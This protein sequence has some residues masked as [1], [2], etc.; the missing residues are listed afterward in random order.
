MSSK[1]EHYYTPSPQSILTVRE[2]GLKLPNGRVYRFKSPSGVFSY[3]R[4]DRASRVLINNAVLPQDGSL[5]DLG[6]GYGC[7][8]IVICKEHE[9]LSLHMSDINER[10]VRFSA[11]NARD[12]N[13]EAD[14]R[15]GNLFEPWT[16]MS[17]DVIVSNPPIAAGRAVLTELVNRAFTSLN[18]GGY[19]ELVAYHNKGGSRLE[20]LMRLVFGNALA[21]VKTG[22]IRVYVS[23]KL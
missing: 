16:N 9:A 6:T 22:G 2:V 15:L 20:E 12:H 23:R 7:I 10:A 17:F 3:G 13:L 14:V 21:V 4:V 1:P 5:L 19:L 8:G 11:M 18:D